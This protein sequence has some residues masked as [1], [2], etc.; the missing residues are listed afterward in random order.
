[1]QSFEPHFPAL[2]TGCSL[3]P[4]ARIVPVYDGPESFRERALDLLK[5]RE[6]LF[7]PL[8]CHLKVSMWPKGASDELKAELGEMIDHHAARARLHHIFK[9]GSP[10]LDALLEEAVNA[11]NTIQMMAA[12]HGH[13]DYIS[14][15]YDFSATL[16]GHDTMVIHFTF[17][18]LFAL[19]HQR[20]GFK[21]L[22][23]PTHLQTT[24]ECCLKE[25]F[26][27]RIS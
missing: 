9:E 11:R 10:E 26:G 15:A 20:G 5:R 14:P 12:E 2:G 13:L 22:H 6:A 21:L 7:G 3:S 16:V 17:G 1:M 23:F 18:G 24:I 19:A 4:S 8:P 25:S 27:E